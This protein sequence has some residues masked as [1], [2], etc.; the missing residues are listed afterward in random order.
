MRIGV[1]RGTDALES[2]K[3]TWDAVYAAD[4]EAH[5][6]LSRAWLDAWLDTYRSPWFVLAAQPEPGAPYVAFLP[7]RI[8]VRFARPRGFYNEIIFAGDQFADYNGFLC[9]PEWEDAAIPALAE[10]LRGA[11]NWAELR[12]DNWRVSD[13]RRRLFLRAFDRVKFRRHAAPPLII[14]GTVDNNACPYADLPDDW[15]AFLATLSANNRQKAR[16][17]LRKTDAGGAFRITVANAETYERDLT[18]LLDLWRARWAGRK[19][20]LTGPIVD[21]N[22]SVLRQVAEQGQLF[23]P[24]FWRGD[25]AVAALA[26]LID[27][28]K[29]RYLFVIT[30]R[31]ETFD[32]IPA[33]FLLHA[34]SIRHAIAHGIRTYDFLRGD[35]PYKYAFASQESRIGT[36]TISTRSRRNLTGAMERRSLRSMMEQARALA[37]GHHLAGAELAYRQILELAPDDALALYRFGLVLAA[38]GDHAGARRALKRSV[39]IAP[40][41]DNAWFALA[42]A[43][44]ALGDLPAALAAARRTLDI[45]PA[46]AIA[47]NMVWRLDRRG[48]APAPM[49]RPPR[50]SALADLSAFNKA[51]FDPG[52]RV[53]LDM[54]ALGDPPKMTPRGRGAR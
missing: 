16:R 12:L 37:D 41:G 9:R 45:Q 38:R 20:R 14:D 34:Y 1:I 8:R 54:A 22:F 18:R 25:E 44:E 49:L 4:P 52:P 11:F 31:D 6:F 35:E 17:L 10:R 26:T 23:L 40:Q 24:T 32:D 50:T 43:H 21:R 53:A 28:V 3:E 19:G 15:D 5:I 13:R 7:L 51:V 33:G 2:L 27:P 47:A 29:R 42:T 36:L 30:G 48:D 46:N 39:E